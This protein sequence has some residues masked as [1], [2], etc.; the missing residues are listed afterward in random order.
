MTR[1]PSASE[2]EERRNAR[3]R[4][5]REQREGPVRRRRRIQ[6]LLLI[7]WIAGTIALLVVAI[8]I[9][10][11]VFFAP[12][13]MAWVEANPGA[14][15]HGLVQDFVQWYRP[16]VLADEPASTEQRRVTVTV[17]SG[18]TDT[19]IGQLLF[20]EGLI[21]S[22]IA[23]QYAVITSGREGTLAAGD[24]DLSPTLK[25][26]QIVAALQGVP[27]G[28]TTSVTIREGLR[29]EE[30]VAAFAASEMTTNIE[31]LAAI[32]QAPPPEILNRTSILADLP[33]G[34]SLE[35]YIPPDTLEYQLSGEDALPTQVVIRLLDHMGDLLT[36]DMREAIRA[37]GLTIDEAIIIA[38]HRRAR[39][40]HGR[41]ASA[42]R[43]RLHQPLPQPRQRGDQRPAQRRPDAPVRPRTGEQRPEGHPLLANTEGAFLPVDQW[44]SVEWWPQLQVGGGDVAVEEVLLGYQ[45]Y[46]Q[47]GLPPTPIA[48]PRIGSIEAVATRRSTRG[49]ST[50]S[51]AARTAPVT[52]RTTSPRH[53][54]STTRTSS[55]PGR[56]RRPVT[57]AAPQTANRLAAVRGVLAELGLD[58]VLLSRT[59][60]KRYFSGFRLSDAEGPTSGYAGNPAGDSRPPPHPR[61]LPLH[62]AGVDRG[63]RLGAGADDGHARRGPAASC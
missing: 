61:R 62:R 33:A 28:P 60:H 57:V 52:D 58:A 44:G 4:Q 3:I 39:G 46:T 5:L 53:S 34:R 36:N 40:G 6:P 55:A 10:F 24:F 47:T 11:N 43:R 22:Q 18:A 21:S 29:L 32:L 48:A 49:C 27:F 13:V 7:T 1:R 14:I 30:V 23:F 51:P 54:R 15:E 17:E 12:R 26:S 16:E 63:S 38:S 2:Y 56:V 41:G 59:A 37:K 50:S 8:I 42:H 20:D 45:T 9:G 25:P 19:S 31:D 35:G